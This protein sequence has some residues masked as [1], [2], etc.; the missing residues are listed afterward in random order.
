VALGS[1]RASLINARAYRANPV[2]FYRKLSGSGDSYHA[3]APFDLFG[4]NV[5]INDPDLVAEVLASPSGQRFGKTGLRFFAVIR[6]MLGSG[7]FGIDGD[8]HQRRRRVLYPVLQGE[9]L[10]SAAAAMSRAA[11]RLREEWAVPPGRTTSTNTGRTGHG[12]I[13]HRPRRRPAAAVGARARLTGRTG[14][15]KPCRDP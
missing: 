12:P 5:L 15:P 11:E 6:R 7:L 14:V 8:Q 9:A 3:V 4:Q 13:V 10:R 1:A 2:A